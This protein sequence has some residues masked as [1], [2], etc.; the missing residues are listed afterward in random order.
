MPHAI[1]K[2][3]TRELKA[4]PVKAAFL[5][6]LGVVALWFWAPLV[7]G[8][9]T[10]EETNE[11]NSDGVSPEFAAAQAA[12]GAPNAGLAA[13]ATSRPGMSWRRLVELMQ[14]DPFKRPLRELATTRDPF[15]APT[16]T[17][18]AQDGD[19]DSNPDAIP[20]SGAFPRELVGGNFGGDEDENPGSSDS[21]QGMVLMATAIG[22]DRRTAVIDGRA[23]QEG[24]QLQG[25]GGVQC[26]VLRIA[27][28][29]VTLRSGDKIWDITQTQG[30]DSSGE[31]IFRRGSGGA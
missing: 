30:T 8:L 26:L 29:R 23:F 12:A 9:F 17:T 1:T 28:R 7:I 18:V 10:G 31:L 22:A 2:Q 25:P 16:Q 19:L 24:D 5:A 20:P 3:L 13:S 21:G 6:T 4:H 15:G 11:V 27:P 14:A